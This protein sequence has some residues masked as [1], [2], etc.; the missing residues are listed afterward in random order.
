MKPLSESR[1]LSKLD[2]I[3]SDFRKVIRRDFEH[4]A[5]SC[6]SCEAPGACC[7]DEHFVN[8]RITRLE[9]AGI[10]KTLN[11]LPN[12]LYSKVRTR[13]EHSIEKYS[14]NEN[15][16]SKTYSCPLFE[17]GIG[18]LVHVTAKPLPC[19]AHACYE[20][21]EDLPPNAL[22]AEREIEI[23]KLN[24]RVYGSTTLLP[25]PLALQMQKT[26]RQ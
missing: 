26:A 11:A 6:A 10:N 4:R 2:E 24:R 21:K 18:C 16:E 23:E 5:K 20:R 9:A 7:M 22:L 8:V 1:A 3:R 19:I 15:E 17:K 12:E 14:L 13:I 25:I